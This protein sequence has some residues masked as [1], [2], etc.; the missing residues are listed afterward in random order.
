MSQSVFRARPLALAMLFWP[1]AV[2]GTNRRTNRGQIVSV[3]FSASQ[4]QTEK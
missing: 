3:R 4:Q 1:A 2:S